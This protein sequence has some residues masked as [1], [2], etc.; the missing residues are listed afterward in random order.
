MTLIENKESRSQEDEIFEVADIEEPEAET[1]NEPPEIEKNEENYEI[2]IETEIKQKESE[3]TNK[4]QVIDTDSELEFE[5]SERVYDEDEYI[6]K[7]AC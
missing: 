2:I 1:K 5:V 4:S 6:E 3:E 7:A